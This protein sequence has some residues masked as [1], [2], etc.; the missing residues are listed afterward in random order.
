M[1]RHPVPNSTNYINA[2]DQYGGLIRAKGLKPSRDRSRQQEQEIPKESLDDMM[3][4]PMNRN[5]RSQ[6][7][8]SE[9]LRDEIYK[10][11]VERGEDVRS[12]SASLQVEMGRVGAVVRLKTLEEDWVK[13]VSL[14]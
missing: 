6:H 12:V 4:Y 5:F 2:Y 13:E 7:V 1:F 14:I 11:V 8:L 9:E 10:R 3:P